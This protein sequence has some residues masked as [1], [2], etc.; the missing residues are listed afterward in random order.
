MAIWFKEFT[1]ADLN[2]RGKNTLADFLGIQFTAIG[3]DTLTA[4]MPVIGYRAWWSKCCIS[5]ND[6]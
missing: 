2:R 1:A 4:T 5:R 6:C 3:D